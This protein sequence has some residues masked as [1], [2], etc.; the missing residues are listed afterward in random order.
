MWYW[1][2]LEGRS[3]SVFPCRDKRPCCPKGHLAA[4]PDPE[5]I[6]DL[7]RRYSGELVGAPTGA[8]NGFDVL[9]IDTNH[10]GEDWL[11]QYECSHALP[12]TR[13]HA[14]RSGGLH[15]FF[16]HRVGLRCSAG[17]LAPGVDIRSSG[18]YCIWW[19]AVGLPVLSEGPIAPWPVPMIELLHEAQQAKRAPAL[20]LGGTQ[21]PGAWK[22]SQDG[23]KLPEELYSKM[24]ELVPVWKRPHDQRRVRGLLRTLVQVRESR[25]HALNTLG[26]PFR[27]LIAA[28][29]ISWDAARELLI[30][31]ARLNGYI[32]KRGLAKAVR[33]IH[34][35][36]GPRP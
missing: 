6:A 4:T 26:F 36:L 33:T 29:A 11:M 3:L 13:I 12:P 27:E 2:E 5:K 22:P 23:W 9:D 24:T 15:V 21:G 7:F 19:P 35:A 32:A 10:S 25:N 1:I 8:V 20:T 14:T 17:L 31:A 28:G 34:S 16:Q 30:E 18:G